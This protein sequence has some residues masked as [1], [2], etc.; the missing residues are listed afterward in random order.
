[1]GGISNSYSGG[2][3]CYLILFGGRHCDCFRFYPSVMLALSETHKRCCVFRP[4]WVSSSASTELPRWCGSQA[5]L[6]P[7][8]ATFELWLICFH[9]WHGVNPL[10]K[11]YV[12]YVCAINHAPFSN[13]IFRW[14][15]TSLPPASPPRWTLEEKQARAIHFLKNCSLPFY[16]RVKT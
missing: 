9:K 3:V 13:K 8:Q 15:I 16:V 5:R 11:H 2:V 14:R 1:M 4:R 12:I 10:C 7:C 6:I